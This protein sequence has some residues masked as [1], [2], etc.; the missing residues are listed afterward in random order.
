MFLQE[1]VKKKVTRFKRNTQ[2]LFQSHL[3]CLLIISISDCKTS[4]EIEL[5]KLANVWRLV[6]SSPYPHTNKHSLNLNVLPQAMFLSVQYPIM[7]VSGDLASTSSP[8]Q[9]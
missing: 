4:H 1:G 2:F 8:I 9:S 5:C 3:V 6:S 7:P